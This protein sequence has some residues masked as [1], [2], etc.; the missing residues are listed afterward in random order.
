MTDTL[1]SKPLKHCTSEELEVAWVGA[2]ALQDSIALTPDQVAARN[3]VA[4]ELDV[5]RLNVVDV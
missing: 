2:S 5:C 1:S 3:A 4:K